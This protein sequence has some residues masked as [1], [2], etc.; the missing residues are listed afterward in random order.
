MIPRYGH[1]GHS[2]AGRDSPDEV[3][4]ARQGA[5]RRA[6]SIEDVASDDQEVWLMLSDGLLN[7][8]QDPV[9]VLIKG[10]P[11]E[12]PSEMPVACV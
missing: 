7:L 10:H 12:V 2:I 4:E 1:D 6:C 8:R 9:M 3:T 11:V 5:L